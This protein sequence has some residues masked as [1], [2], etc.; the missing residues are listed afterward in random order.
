MKQ[1]ASRNGR[2]FFWFA[3][4]EIRGVML[5]LVIGVVGRTHGGSRLLG[6]GDRY[7]RPAC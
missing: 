2:S 1:N 5:E 4:A 6:V 7:Y 3:A